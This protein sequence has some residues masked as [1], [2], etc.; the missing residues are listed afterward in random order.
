MKKNNAVSLEVTSRINI[1]VYSRTTRERRLTALILDDPFW[2]MHDKEYAES[3]FYFNAM[4]KLSQIN[5]GK[6][7]VVNVTTETT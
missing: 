4:G 5:R 6:W 7:R 3:S 2:D 1:S